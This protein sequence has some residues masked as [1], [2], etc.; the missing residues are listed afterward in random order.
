MFEPVLCLYD[1]HTNHWPILSITVQ[2]ITDPAAP[3]AKSDHETPV[4]HRPQN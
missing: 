4:P 1:N 2:T 3:T